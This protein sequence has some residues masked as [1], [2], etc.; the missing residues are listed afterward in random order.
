LHDIQK[1]LCKP[2]ISR[3]Q[4]SSR[5]LTKKRQTQTFNIHSIQI[6]KLS[7]EPKDLTARLFKKL[8]VTLIDKANK[9]ED[10]GCISITG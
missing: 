6:N 7:K 2:Y 4:I 10:K 5:N 1:L 9:K 3:A 8:W